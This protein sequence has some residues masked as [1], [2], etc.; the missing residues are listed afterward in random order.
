[1]SSFKII[2]VNEKVSC[3]VL[4]TSHIRVQIVFFAVLALLLIL[5][6]RIFDIS[7]FSLNEMQ[8]S[9]NSNNKDIHIR[10]NITDRNGVI[11]AST[12]PTASAYIYPKHFAHHDLSLTLIAQEIQINPHEIKEK[13]AQNNNFIWLKRHLTPNEQQR[14]HDL[15]VPGIYFMNDQ[16][17]I[18]PHKNLFSHIVGLVDIDN[19]GISGIEASFNSVLQDDTNQDLQIT[20][21]AKIQYIAK[22]ELANAIDMHDAAGGAAIIMDIHT[23]EL[24]SSVSLPDFDPYNIHDIKNEK[25]FNRATLGVYELGSVFKTL[26]VAMAIDSEKITVRDSFNVSTPLKINSY[27]IGDYRGG[28][29]GVLSVPEILMYSS[30]IGVAQIV[31]EVGIPIQKDYFKKLG[32][33]SKINLEIPE[34]SDPIYPSDHRWKEVSSITMGYG[35]GISV[36]PVHFIQAFSA[37]VNDGIFKKAT[38]VKGKSDGTKDRRVFKKKTSLLM[39]NILRLTAK[40]GSAKYANINKYLVGGKSGTASI[41][42]KGGY[43]KHLNITTC[44]GAFPMNNPKYSILVVVDKPKANKINYGFTT[45]GMIAAPVVSKIISR[46]AP[47]LNIAPVDHNAPEITKALYVNYKPMYKRYAKANN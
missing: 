36:T 17:R 43:S 13:L 44:A 23:G 20:L 1:M 27:T 3:E 21:D 31:Q 26:A 18:Y 37:V 32:L 47:I 35:H 19:K 9:S 6:L 38:L 8:Y 24:L 16:K 11:L 25:F 34:I 2:H 46:I 5:V 33:L 4:K 45:G 41:A 39:K 12:L 22:Q 10:K 42:Q 28:K 30:N 7:V 40:S 29:G 15:G 14:L